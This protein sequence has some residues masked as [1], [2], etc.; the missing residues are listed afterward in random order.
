MMN[1]RSRD[2]V[3]KVI[4]HVRACLGDTTA[5]MTSVRK[6]F[7]EGWGDGLV[8]WDKIGEK[9]ARERSSAPHYKE[10][11]AALKEVDLALGKAQS[12]CDRLASTAHTW[13][14]QR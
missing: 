7:D 10:L 5:A 13:G 3:L 11:V 4:A 8:Y 2:Q 14:D 6:K 9:L 1:A 12:A